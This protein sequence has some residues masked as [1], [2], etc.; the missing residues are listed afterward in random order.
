[1]SAVVSLLVVIFVALAL[2]VLLVSLWLFRLSRG[3]QMA[4]C[5]Y[6]HKAIQRGA[7]ACPYCGR[8]LV[9][10]EVDPEAYLTAED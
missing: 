6:C 5:P 9:V 3:P 2:V 7:S 4:R 10:P 8:Q 1:M